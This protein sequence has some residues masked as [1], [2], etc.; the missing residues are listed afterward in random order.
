M[1]AERPVSSCNVLCRQFRIGKA[2]RLRILHN[3]LGLKSPSSLGAAY[4]I[5]QLEQQ[6]SVIFE[7][8][9]DGSDRIKGEPFSTEYHPG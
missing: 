2:T 7:V 5:N 3:E 4:P 1:L 8:S 6:K 9:S